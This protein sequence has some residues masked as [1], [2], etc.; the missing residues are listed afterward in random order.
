MPTVAEL[1]RLDAL[2]GKLTPLSQTMQGE[3]IRAS[4]WNDLVGTVIELART[5][6]A[7]AKDDTIPQHVHT[8]QV[9]LA[10][11]DPRLRALIERG[12]MA[13]PE[14]TGR[15]AAVERELTR[16]RDRFTT[17]DLGV[18]EVRDRVTEI[19]TRDL[20]RESDVTET[21]RRID[22]LSDSRSEITS[23]R[24]TLASVQADLG[25]AIDV[26]RRLTVNG[27]PLDP[28]VLLDRLTDVEA[29][30]ERLRTPTGELL[31]ASVYER[32][33]TEL[34]NTLVTQQ[35]LEDALNQRRPRLNAPERAAM[36]EELRTELTVSLGTSID[37][38][39]D[40]LRA[41]MVA[42]L[43][44]IDSRVNTA[45]SSAVPGI[46][47]S[48]ATSVRAEFETSLDARAI[49]IETKAAADLDQRE[50]AIRADVK[51]SDDAMNT[52]IGGF[53]AKVKSAVDA[54]RTQ[55]LADAARR[56]L[57][58]A[59]LE[60]Q[61]VADRLTADLTAL[62][63]ANMDSLATDLTR[64]MQTTIANET[65]RLETEFKDQLTSLQRGL[66]RLVQT[67]F[68][69][70]QPKLDAMVDTSVRRHIGR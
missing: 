9:G 49:Q 6:L 22:S 33:L 62:V 69:N 35:E 12:P 17:V 54:M 51:A 1:D 50:A 19:S 13:D 11:L 25:T 37:R 65:G 47:D 44:D 41:E 7:S 14:A 32:K 38:S 24:E 67:E 70:F 27:Q 64:T 2:I 40:E 30:H 28:T 29:V 18:R 45:V 15:L 8:E 3:L 23:M 21:R 56:A 39:A 61:A 68:Q 53:D 31:D 60:T 46:R 26:G 42:K 57:A 43:S 63:K 34:E 59:Q 4:A 58:I 66:P 52:A 48:V 16:T 20:K 55:V 36:V 10:W 5:V